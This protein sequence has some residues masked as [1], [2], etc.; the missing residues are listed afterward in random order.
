MTLGAAST[1]F[2]LLG[3]RVRTV[4]YSEYLSSRDFKLFEEVFQQFGLL[5][6]IKYST[7]TA[8]AED[9]TAYKGDIRDLTESLLRGTLTMKESQNCPPEIE[10]LAREEILLV[11]EVDVFFGADFYGQTYNQVVKFG[12]PEVAI[13][14]KTIW[15]LHCK[16]VR[17]R[18]NDVKFMPE[19][20]RLLK[21]LSSFEFLLDNEIS[22]MLHQVK[23][24][25]DVPYYL[26]PET[27]RIGYKVMDS[28]SYDVTY[29]YASIFA[30]LKESSSL[31][32]GD[33]LFRALVMPI[34]CGQFSYANISPARILGVSGTLASMSEFEKDVLNEYGLN[35]FVY[36]PSVYGDSNF[37]FDQAGVGIYFEKNTSNFYHRIF[38]EIMEAT[39]SKRAVIVFFRDRAKLNAFISS[40]TYQ[41]LGRNK[42][43]L[44]EDMPSSDKEFV[45]NKAATTRQIT[46]CTA[47]FGRGTDFFCKDENVEKNGGVHI[48]QTFLSEEVSE[49][50]QIQGRTA[51]QGK[52]GSYQMILLESELETDFGIS[53]AQKNEIPKHNWY[54]WLCGV[55]SRH[56]REK[57]LLVEKNLEEATEKDVIT[58]DY[59][60]SLIARKNSKAS[61][62]FKNLYL[63]MK[64][65]PLPSAVGLDL[66]FAIDVTGSMAPYAQ[67]AA[68]TVKKLIR[69]P[70]SIVEKL[71]SKFPEIQFMLRVGFLG[72]R[73]IGDKNQF[74]ESVWSDGSHFTENMSDANKFIKDISKAPSGGFDVAEDHIGAINRITTS[75][76]HTND[77]F[78]E[79][80]CLLLLSDAPSHGL[81]SEDNLLTINSDNYPTRHPDGLTAK[82]TISHLLSEGI[83][84]FFCSFNPAATRRTEEEISTILTNHPDNS[85]ERDVIRIPMVPVNKYKSRSS[86][87]DGGQGRHIIFVLDE[88]GSMSNSWAGVVHAYR[89]YKAKRQQSQS[90]SDLVSVI[91]FSSS[92]RITV[93]MQPLS[94]ATGNLVYHGGGTSFNPAACDA[95]SLARETPQTHIPAIIFMS[96]GKAS[97]SSSAAREFSKLNVYI[98]AKS[99]KDLEL[100]VISFGSCTDDAQLQEIA[101]ASQGG[102]VHASSNIAELAD[103]FVSIATNENVSTLLESEIAKRISE[104]VSD[105]LTCEYFRS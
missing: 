103:V 52:K 65:Q 24:V 29:G 27:D 22:L 26:D 54:Q 77:W 97:D 13:I 69:G 90:E 83:D 71:K 41:Q 96:D 86:S 20:K 58:Y 60:D 50:V 7:I 45:I 35:K 5:T 101:S 68:S 62:Q 25:D 63:L 91:Q 79:I 82:N 39:K 104:A 66:A 99:E 47:V 105:K 48:I 56:Q 80:K 28:I 14:L 53:T 33:T 21:K 46:L 37:N 36:I 31:K 72:Y 75:W 98:S 87:L 10:S 67:C 89:K 3:F 49:E 84:L 55:R 88:S 2:A 100:H 74:Q 8:F 92:S 19:Y 15:S 17:L 85:S 81:V 73:D 76:N 42:K 70:G 18:L 6:F 102:R 34:S 44:T 51:R 59:F 11:D 57:S 40:P 78:S 64:K 23:M 43:H 1:M 95:C 32:N 94:V 93:R 30:Y 61:E 12:E 16:G 4:C 38:S 9:S